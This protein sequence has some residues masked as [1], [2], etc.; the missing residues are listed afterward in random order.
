MEHRRAPSAS[1]HRSPSVRDRRID[2]TRGAVITAFNALLF[3]RGYARVSVRDVIDRANVGRSTFY[4]HFRNKHDVLEQAMSPVLTP[5]ADALTSRPDDAHLV[6]VVK[7][8]WEMREL[9]RAI[10]TGAARPLVTQLLARMLKD[11]LERGSPLPAFA[12]PPLAAAALAGAQLALLEAWIADPGPLTAEAVAAALAA[13]T[14]GAVSA[15]NAASRNA[16]PGE[17][18]AARQSRAA[19]R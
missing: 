19:W 8:L 13:M 18:S 5:L 11:R 9:T 16:R 2:R 14:A 3:E 10:F 7:H 4:E 12:P 15:L 1:G 6:A 17:P